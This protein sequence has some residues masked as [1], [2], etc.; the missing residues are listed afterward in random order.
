LHTHCT[1]LILEGANG[2]KH[3]ITRLAAHEPES[4]KA[5]RKIL[6]KHRG[7][8]QTL[9]DLVPTLTWRGFRIPV[10]SEPKFP[11]GGSWVQAPDGVD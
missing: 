10:G 2:A 8:Y 9:A 4:G 5:Y 1:G 3:W 6:A 11:L 7:F